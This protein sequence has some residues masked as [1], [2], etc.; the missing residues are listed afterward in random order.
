MNCSVLICIPN[1]L[2]QEFPFDLLVHPILTL[3]LLGYIRL[4]PPNCDHLW[5]LYPQ[6]WSWSLTSPRLI[7]CQSH[8]YLCA[9]RWFIVISQILMHF[10]VITVSKRPWQQRPSGPRLNIKTVLSTQCIKPPAMTNSLTNWLLW[11]FIVISSSSQPFPSS[12]TQNQVELSEWATGCFM[13]CLRM[14][15]SMLKIRRPL[16]R[17]IFNMGIAIPGKTVFLIETAPW[18]TSIRHRSDTFNFLGL[19]YPGKVK[20][21]NSETNLLHCILISDK[22][23]WHGAFMTQINS[24]WPSDTIK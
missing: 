17:L 11:H 16:G 21:S 9:Y 4:S 7:T 20:A 15:I 19:C 10:L 12:S 13:H 22:S 6:L 24:L 1:L 5:S 3:P 8:S 14:A 23:S 18:L 2:I